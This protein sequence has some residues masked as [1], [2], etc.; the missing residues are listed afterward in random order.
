[1]YVRLYA[2]DVAVDGLFTATLTVILL[3]V[4]RSSLPAAPRG[5]APRRGR[6]LPSVQVGSHLHLSQSGRGFERGVG[7]A[8]QPSSPQA[9]SEKPSLTVGTSG[10]G[11]SP[12]PHRRMLLWGEQRESL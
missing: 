8:E 12:P 7:G 4:T 9:V 6:L 11:P 10:K 2:P 1:M 5:V 3:T